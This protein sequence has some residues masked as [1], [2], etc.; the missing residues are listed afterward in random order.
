MLI[1]DTS[2]SIGKIN[3]ETKVQPFLKRFVS[4]PKLN[5]NRDGTQIGTIRFSTLERT[6]IILKFNKEYNASKI[7]KMIGDL[8]WDD[9]VGSKTGT[10]TALKM[11]DE[12]VIS[13]SIS[14][15]QIFPKLKY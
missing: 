15:K 6:E 12:Q 4:H 11:A 2:S 10:E 13:K 3:F 5:V 14:L 8:Q 7:A 1:V 9:V